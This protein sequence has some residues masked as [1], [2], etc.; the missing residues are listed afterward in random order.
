MDTNVDPAV[1]AAQLSDAN[2]RLQSAQAEWNYLDKTCAAQEA[3]ARKGRM[4]Q[5]ELYREIDTLKQ[6][7]GNN[8]A[9]ATILTAQDAAQAALAA[10]E[11][12]REAIRSARLE[13]DALNARMK[14]AVEKAE[15]HAA[16]LEAPKE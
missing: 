4:R 5:E 2:T 3:E 9:V 10:A 12:E 1:V 15:A 16:S 6:S 7:I 14:A 11:Q 13:A 8:N